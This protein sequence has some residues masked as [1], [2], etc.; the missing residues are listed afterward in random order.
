M[1]ETSALCVL[2]DHVWRCWGEPAKSLCWSCFFPK[3]LMNEK[4]GTPLK[5]PDSKCSRY[6]NKKLPTLRREVQEYRDTLLEESGV[7]LP[8]ALPTVDWELHTVFWAVRWAVRGPVAPFREGL[9][10]PG[11]LAT[12]PFG[13]EFT[14]EYLLCLQSDFGMS[15]DEVEDFRDVVDYMRNRMSDCMEEE[16]DE[17]NRACAWPMELCQDF[18]DGHARM[19]VGL[20]VSDVMADLFAML[21][22][23]SLYGP[24]DYRWEMGYIFSSRVV[25]VGT[26]QASNGF[27]ESASRNGNLIKYPVLTRVTYDLDSVDERDY[28][29]CGE[30]RHLRDIREI[31]FG[32]AARD[33]VQ[34]DVAYFSLVERRVEESRQV[35]VS[36][37]QARI[38]QSDE[39]WVIRD[40][41]S[42][43]GTLVVS[44]SGDRY[45]VGGKGNE[46]QHRALEN[47]DIICFGY[48]DEEG[49]FRADACM[50]CYL[51]ALGVDA[52]DLP[53]I[54]G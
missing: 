11:L 26:E 23:T 31:R 48:S 40:W 29:V 18:V 53:T 51:F 3:V 22:V 44:R 25:R 41:K 49:V 54:E 30:D 9:L 15:S 34:D 35:G 46:R 1:A 10:N 12:E 43:F 20:A 13:E 17:H 8:E 36:R 28:I 27:S 4:D 5:N 24:R 33:V 50:P 14:Q 21:F 6:P 47:G 38:A 7:R 52:S 32:R 42:S 37:M 19:G 45:V 39:G 16:N 2:M